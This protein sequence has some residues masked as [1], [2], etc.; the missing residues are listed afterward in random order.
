MGADEGVCSMSIQMLTHSRASIKLKSQPCFTVRRSFKRAPY[1]FPL[2]QIFKQCHIFS[3]TIFFFSLFLL[4][5]KSPWSI[6]YPCRTSSAAAAASIIACFPKGILGTLGFYEGV[7]S[8]LGF[9][10]TSSPIPMTGWPRGWAV[11]WT[12]LSL[13]HDSRATWNE[14]AEK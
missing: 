9:T 4:A 11:G 6:Y 14:R 2:F 12:V 1:S 3:L 13:R 10:D 8:Y 5:E 7:I